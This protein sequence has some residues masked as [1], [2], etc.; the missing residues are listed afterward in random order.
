[1]AKARP[2]CRELYDIFGAECDRLGVSQCRILELPGLSSPGVAYAWTPVVLVPEDLDSYLDREQLIDVLCHELIHVRRRDFLWGMV[3]DVISC[4]LFFHPA[5]WL[6]LRDLSRE[7]ELA[8]DEAVMQLRS[9]RR[10]NYASCLTRL[11]RRRVLGCQLNPTSHLALLSSFLAFR[12]QVLLAENRRL[13]RGKRSAAVTASLAAVLVL[14]TGW[15][16]LSLAIEVAHAPT[17][18][19]ASTAAPYPAMVA[20][21]RKARGLSKKNAVQTPSVPATSAILSELDVTSSAPASDG[22]NRDTWVPPPLVNLGGSLPDGDERSTSVW[23][24]EQPSTSKLPANAPTLPSL[25][26]TALNAAIGALGHL[27]GR[28]PDNDRD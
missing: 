6:A 8:C 5:V 13:S 9:G 22:G 18:D 24:E 1:M 25:P 10:A 19:A 3:G 2:V 21:Y 12:V 11:A 15:S 4:L 23:D 17:V 7:R 16:F 20:A 14:F 28:R 27:Q 26:R